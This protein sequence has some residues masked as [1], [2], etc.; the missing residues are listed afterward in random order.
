MEELNYSALDLAVFVSSMDLSCREESRV[1]ES[2]WAG[3]NELL[4]SR[5]KDNLRQFILDVRYWLNYF[6][7]KPV[8][9]KEFP[10][11]QKDLSRLEHSLQTGEYFSDFTDLDLFFKA[12]R[13]RILYCGEKYVRIKLRTLL[14]RYGYKR[15]TPQLMAHIEQS[16]QFFHLEAALRG[17]VQCS[18]RDINL[19]DMLT[20]RVG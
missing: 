10:A 6:Y 9:D 5:Y 20:F 13:I 4:S 1:I 12:M 14:A 7:E 17:G 18:I 2:I 8:L 16:M 3:E 11:V 19:D 15:R